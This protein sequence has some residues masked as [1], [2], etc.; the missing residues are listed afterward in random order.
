VLKMT[1]L[2]IYK[3]SEKIP[4]F[5]VSTIQQV[6]ILQQNFNGETGLMF[7]FSSSSLLIKSII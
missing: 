6:T 5:E 4:Y 1:S 2:G 3:A 7:F